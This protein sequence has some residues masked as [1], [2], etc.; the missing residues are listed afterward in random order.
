[1]KRV[2]KIPYTQI[3]QRRRT[4]KPFCLCGCNRRV[5]SWRKNCRYYE[6]ACIPPEKRSAWGG[7]NTRKSAYRV[8]AIKFQK[9]LQQLGDRI[10]REDL[11]ACFQRIYEC[12]YKS[13]HDA[14]RHFRQKAI[15]DVA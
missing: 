3:G 12:G 4:P 6:R 10:T 1:M 14:G 5:K 2:R 9:E 13:G 11:L 7:M 15:R 8:R